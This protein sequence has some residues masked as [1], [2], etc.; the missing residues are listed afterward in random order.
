MRDDLGAVT[1]AFAITGVAPVGKLAL[2][3]IADASGLDGH[4]SGDLA[5]LRAFTNCKT[6]A[7]EV[8]WLIDAGYLKAVP[9]GGYALNLDIIQPAQ[10]AAIPTKQGA[11]L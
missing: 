1:K 4:W 9:E 8:R 10:P 7:H 6:I 2:I 5:K 3:G 11:L